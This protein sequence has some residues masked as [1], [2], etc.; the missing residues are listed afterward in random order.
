M[1]ISPLR[2]QSK[3]ACFSPSKLAV[4]FPTIS[5]AVPL[6]GVVIGTGKPPIVAFMDF[7]LLMLGKS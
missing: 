4:F 3:N 5:K 7:S 1:R 6:A 2:V